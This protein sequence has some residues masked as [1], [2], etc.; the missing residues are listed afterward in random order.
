MWDACASAHC[1]CLLCCIVGNSYHLPTS[2]IIHTHKKTPNHLILVDETPI[3]VVFNTQF[4]KWDA[5]MAQTRDKKINEFVDSPVF[6]YFFIFILCLQT[7]VKDST[8]IN[9][10]KMRPKWCEN[11]IKIQ[12]S[13]EVRFVH[14]N[15]NFVYFD[16][17]KLFRFIFIRDRARNTK[18][19]LIGVINQFNLFFKMWQT[20]RQTK[21]G[22]SSGATNAMSIQNWECNPLLSHHISAISVQKSGKEN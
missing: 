3:C 6:V 1:V 8:E 2:T 15:W 9:Q 11:K 17:Y 19:E 13:R 16:S 5:R 4:T 7:L 21:W 18:R 14:Q 10:I 12:I 20:F 22:K